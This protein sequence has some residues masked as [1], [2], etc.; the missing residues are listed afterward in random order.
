MTRVARRLATA[1]LS[2]GIPLG[3]P[4]RS[5]A[6]QPV[7]TAYTADMSTTTLKILPPCCCDRVSIRSRM[8]TIA[9]LSSMLA[10]ATIALGQTVF[11]SNNVTRAEAIKAASKLK[12]GMWEEDASKQLATN[13]LKYAMGVGGA[14]GWDRCYGLSDGTSLHLSY[15][16]REFKGAQWGGNGVLQK[17]FIQ[18]N[19]VNIVFITLT[20]ALDRAE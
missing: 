1:G 2:D 6:R 12:A 14:V 19:G 20:N 10:L 15:R 9:S 18:S 11:Y 3:F 13:E 5:R 17:A 8:K 16:P 7:I 4:D